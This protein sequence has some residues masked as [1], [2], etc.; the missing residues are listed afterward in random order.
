[1]VVMG[2]CRISATKASTFTGNKNEVSE[3]ETSSIYCM[4]RSSDLIT[5][6]IEKERGMRP[7]MR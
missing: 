6:C 7:V 5:T 4:G 2:I 3:Q 1:M